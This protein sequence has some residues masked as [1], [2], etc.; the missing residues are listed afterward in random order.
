[1]VKNHCLAKSINDASWYQFRIWLEYSGSQKSEVCPMPYALCPMP[2]ALCPVVPHLSEKGYTSVKYLERLR[3]RWTHSTPAFECSKCGEIVKKT[4]ST[5]TQVCKCGCVMDR[6]FNAARNILRR[7]L[8]TAG[9]VGTF[10]LEPSNAL[11]ELTSTVVG[12]ILP[13]QAGS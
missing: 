10:G 1:M 8:G 5:R 11:G 2:Y 9:H 7:G 6:D 13:Q 12:E 3:L 4:L